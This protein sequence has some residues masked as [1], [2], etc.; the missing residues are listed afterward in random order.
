[1]SR[2]RSYVHDHYNGRTRDDERVGVLF[3]YLFFFY[4]RRTT[5][6]RSKRIEQRLSR[7][8]RTGQRAIKTGHVC[9]VN[10]RRVRNVIFI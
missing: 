6:T 7:V 4:I 10:V 1:M 9:N 3:I 5:R 2:D 8:Y